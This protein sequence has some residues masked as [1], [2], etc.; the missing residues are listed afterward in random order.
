[1]KT[2]KS[3]VTEVAEP[4]GGDEARFKKRHVDATDKK[5]YPIKGQEHIFKGKAK[6]PARVA[7]IDNE[8]EM[9]DD[10][11]DD[12]DEDDEDEG[13]VSRVRRNLRSKVSESVLI[14]AV[15]PG[16][17]KLKDGSTQ[18]IAKEDAANLNKLFSQ[19]NPQNK[20]KMEERMTKSKEGFAEILQFSKNV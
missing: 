6:A 16:T 4:I 9:Y 14:E 18:K 11:Y 15:K 12:E 17:V 5:D 8:E 10:Q 2:F 3:F 20:S 7:D 19:L 1:M 13:I